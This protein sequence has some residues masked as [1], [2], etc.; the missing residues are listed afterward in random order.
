MLKWGE[1]RK[2]QLIQFDT[3]IPGAPNTVTSQKAKP[4]MQHF[5]S[6]AY[7][8]VSIVCSNTFS[9]F[10]TALCATLCQG[11][12]DCPSKLCIDAVCTSHLSFIAHLLTPCR[13]RN[14][15]PPVCLIAT[16]EIRHILPV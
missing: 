5:S 14:A 15:Q 3:A 4:E 12:A 2:E 13:N 6:R 16:V 11:D 10:P 1:Y 8:G 9:E 7:W